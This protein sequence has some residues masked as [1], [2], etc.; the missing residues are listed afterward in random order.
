LF[1]SLFEKRTAEN[2]R[3]LAW[4]ASADKNKQML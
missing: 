2:H 3:K 4:V 1:V